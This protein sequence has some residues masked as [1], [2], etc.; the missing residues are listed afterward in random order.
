MLIVLVA[1][2]CSCDVQGQYGV[3]SVS[4]PITHISAPLKTL[5]LGNLPATANNA[6]PSLWIQGDGGWVQYATIPQG[7]TLT[8]IAISPTGGNGLL[9]EVLNETAYGSNFYFYPSSQLTFFA[10]RIGQHILSFS[11]DGQTSNQIVID[12]IAYAPPKYYQRPS[13][14]YS[15]SGPGYSYRIYNPYYS[16]GREYP[17]FYYGYGRKYPPFYYGYG[18]NASYYPWL[19]PP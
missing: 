10:D 14:Y 2:A 18:W 5:I 11:I 8:L 12:V 6:A 1:I 17:P 7:L 13:P 16:H 15:G 3:S 4:A 19:S 9:N